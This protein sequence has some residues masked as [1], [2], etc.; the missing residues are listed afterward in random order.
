MVLVVLFK[1]LEQCY[2]AKVCRPVTKF[3]DSERRRDN[4]ACMDLSKAV[5]A[6]ALII[7]LLLSAGHALTER[8]P[9]AA[10]S[11]TKV[12]SAG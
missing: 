5:A 9:P 7:I 8:T 1:G 4:T 3:A 12:R 11:E 10:Q 2:R 6:A